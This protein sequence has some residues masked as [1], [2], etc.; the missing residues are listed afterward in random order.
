MVPGHRQGSLRGLSPRRIARSA[1]GGALSAVDPRAGRKPAGGRAGAE[2]SRARDILRRFRP[3]ARR[4]LDLDGSVDVG[5][6]GDGDVNVAVCQRDRDSSRPRRR[7]RRRP[8]QRPRQRRSTGAMVRNGLACGSL[9]R[10]RARRWI[11]LPLRGKK[12]CGAAL[13]ARGREPL[14]GGDGDEQRNGQGA[15]A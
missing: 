13:V 7:R 12:S 6:D 8:G 4:G 1:A 3:V 5:V 2:I 9:E 14:H 11:R 10:A 15:F